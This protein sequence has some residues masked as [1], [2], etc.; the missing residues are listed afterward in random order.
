MNEERLLEMLSNDT[1]KKV[2]KAARS[3]N[4]STI[5]SK[6]DIIMRIKTAILTDDS[7]FRK[8]FSNI[9]GNSGGWLT[10]SCLHGV[11]YYLK[12]LLR[13]ES[14][15]D[16]ID[17]LLSMKHIPNVVVIDMAY[18][19]ARHALVSRREDV[20]KYGYNEEGILFRPYSDRV[21]DPDDSENVTI[22]KENNL[23]LSFPWILQEHTINQYS[24]HKLSDNNEYQSLHPITN[25]DVHLCLF[26]RFHENNTSSEIETLRK[27]GYVL[28]LKGM[29]NSQVEEQLH[30]QF[31]S[32][33]KFLNMMTPVIH[34]YLFR[35]ILDHHNFN[36]SKTVTN[37]L[38]QKTRFKLIFDSLGRLQFK[39]YTNT[40]F[41]SPSSSS[42]LFEREAEVD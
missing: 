40:N 16:Y 8:I 22:A 19:I 23:E 27:I 37:L 20:Q 28:E 35:S 4:V 3:C 41:H 11:V 24:N 31:D 15:R 7:K 6:I 29:F 26:D 32:N 14:S 39:T 1:L 42:T 21:A 5:G 18:I 9:W 17:G 2:K 30:L 34:I 12:F 10:F 38:Q 13:S 33:K 36:K 25:S